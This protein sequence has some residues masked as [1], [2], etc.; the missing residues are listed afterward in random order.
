M[1]VPVIGDTNLGAAKNAVDLDGGFVAFN[2]CVAEVELD[3]SKDGGGSPA[4]EVLA[5]DAAFAAAKDC[6]GVEHVGGI[7]GDLLR[8][9]RSQ[10]APDENHANGND[11]DRP[12]IGKAQTSNAEGV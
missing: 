12:K 7:G 3:A 6:H 2:L 4:F 8:D 10:G 9:G 1:D 11:R 5:F